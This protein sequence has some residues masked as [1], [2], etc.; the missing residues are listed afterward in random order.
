MDLGLWDVLRGRKPFSI[1]QICISRRLLQKQKGETLPHK[2][3]DPILDMVSRLGATC[4]SARNSTHALNLETISRSLVASDRLRQNVVSRLISFFA[5]SS[6]ML[7]LVDS[8]HF[9]CPA[10]PKSHA[11]AR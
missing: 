3:A 2:S 9:T 6:G 5:S 4:R 11:V 8:V 10:T 7:S 1:Q